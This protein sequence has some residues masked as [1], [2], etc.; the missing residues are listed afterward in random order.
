MKTL[1]AQPE[2][3]AISAKRGFALVVTLTLMVLLSILALGMLSL[4]AVELRSMSQSDSRSVARANALL[5]LQIAIGELQAS[6]GPDKRITAPGGVLGDTAGQQMITGVWKSRKLGPTSSASDFSK[7]TKGS[8]FVRWLV[9]SPDRTKT[10]AQ[11][12]AE[13]A[14]TPSKDVVDLVSAAS[15]DSGAPSGNV[16]RVAKVPLKGNLGSKKDVL[17]GAYAYAVLDEGIKAR[18]N[19]GILKPS[20]EFANAS[21]SLGAG[22]RPFLGGIAGIGTLEAGKVDL[23]KPVGRALTAKM[24]S[25]QTAEFAYGSPKDAMKRKI[26]DL[27]SS[28]VG[29]LADVANGGLKKDLNLLAEMKANGGLPSEYAGRKIYEQSFDTNIVSDPSWDRALAWAGIFNSPNFTKPTVAGTPTLTASA[30]PG[31][32]AGTG[33]SR[34]SATL[35]LAEPPGPVLLPSIAKVQLSFALAARDVHRYNKGDPK[36]GADANGVK[37][38]LHGPWG[39]RF[40]E[41]R[42]QSNKK[43]ESPFD[44]LLHMIYSPIITLH[45]PYNVPLSFSGMRVEFVNVPF[46]FQV[47]KNGI[48]QT[49]AP[50]PFGM[51]YDVS[52]N[53][54]DS[55]RFGLTLTDTL[56][57]GEVKVYSPKI[58]ASLGRLV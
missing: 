56:L 32:T 2:L 53:G 7:T 23:L 48:A 46:A 4:S 13:T 37:P 35:S 57:P 34:G 17:T 31:W 40:Q 14:P 16:V 29:I 9:S 54:G 55:K 26:H 47:F 42:N 49:K 8:D 1:P 44:Y 38:Q 50:V 21:T 5:A 3:S 6:A 36:L 15:L 20:G 10:E 30:P 12:F 45:N 39:D 22:Q 52:K 27:T 51:M 24:A 18:V 19:L 41:D 58:D 43:V 33:V 11:N 25:L 28:S